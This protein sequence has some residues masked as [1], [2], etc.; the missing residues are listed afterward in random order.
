MNA[1][2]TPVFILAAGRGE[3]MRPL[4][5]HTPK[6]L[7][8][9]GEHCLI[10]HHLHK[11]A[12]QG[13]KQILINHAHLGQQI[14]DTI[15]D[16]RR[17]HLNINYSDESA[18]GALETAGGIINALNKINN[19][20]FIVINGDIWTDFDFSSLL[21]P[22]KKQARLVLVNNP[23]H[24]PKGD[25]F[26]HNNGLV[27]HDKQQTCLTFSGIALYKKTLFESLPEGKQPLAPLLIKAMQNQQ[28]E[29]IHY[30]GEWIDIGT[31]ERLEELREQ[32]GS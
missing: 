21:K 13:F 3:R 11:L 32:V 25:F 14:I 27:S 19:E 18:S 26:L 15:G 23:D 17:Y 7:L 10:E 6:P 22:M 30:Q 31:P 29:G 5:D 2:N 8:K 12:E 4:T 9:V 20:H 16:G 24:H 1:L 28:V